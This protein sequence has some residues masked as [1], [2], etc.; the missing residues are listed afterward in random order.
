[1]AQLLLAVK[2]IHNKGLTIMNVEASNVLLKSGLKDFEHIVKLSGYS[3]VRKAYDCS[4]HAI[5]YNLP[6]EHLTQGKE[7]EVKETEGKETKEP[8]KDEPAGEPHLGN[9]G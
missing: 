7:T 5:S 1:M 2:H 4:H 3:N 6:P 8:E 9:Y